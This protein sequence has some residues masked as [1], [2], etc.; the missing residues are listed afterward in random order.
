M[1]R[2][3]I[4]GLLAVFLAGRAEAALMPLAQAELGGGYAGVNGGRTASGLLGSAFVMPSYEIGGAFAF[5]PAYSFDGFVYD[6]AVEEATFFESRQVHTAMVGFRE[7]LG[8]GTE[9]RLFLEGAYA[10]TRETRDESVGAGLYDYRDLGARGSIEFPGSSSGVTG[11]VTLNVRAYDR[12]YPHYTSLAVLNLGTLAE[13]DPEAAVAIGGRE[14][15]PKDHVGAEVGV[16][17]D[18]RW[19]GAVTRLGYAVAMRYFGDRYL[20]TSQGEFADALRFDNSHQLKAETAFGGWGFDAEAVF[21][22]SNASVFRAEQTHNPYIP[23]F[24]QYVSAGLG[25]WIRWRPGFIAGGKFGMRLGLGILGRW[26]TNRPAQGITGTHLDTRQRDTEASAG[27][28]FWYPLNGWANAVAGIDARQARSNMRYERFLKYNYEVV[29]ASVGVA[30]SWQPRAAGVAPVRAPMARADSASQVPPVADTAYDAEGTAKAL[31]EL[32]VSGKVDAVLDQVRAVVDA[33]P[34]NWRAW[35][36]L[37]ACLYNKG[38]KAGALAAFDKSLAINPANE[39]LRGF[40]DS[41]KGSQ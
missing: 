4:P 15:K 17:T 14:K 32:Y 16:V 18:R 40:A 2:V 35:Q 26:Y 1:N 37:G 33:D 36:L 8:G 13:R 7:T 5:L 21:N 38:D 9:A 11:P 3:I 30:V 39:K 19:T 34:G 22:A 10:F 20:R 27:L 12:V 24:Y 41:L 31:Q 28:K 23:H 25:P 29:M 6:R